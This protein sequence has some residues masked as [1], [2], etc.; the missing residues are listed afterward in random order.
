M[1]AKVLAELER[2]GLLL[3][4]DPALPSVATLVAGER[5]SGSWWG[6]P[7]G[8]RI[9]AVLSE[10]EV[11][12]D[13]VWSRLIARKVTLVHARLVPALIGVGRSRA[14]WQL[15]GLSIEAKKLLDDVDA[16]GSVRATGKPAKE[17]EL[18]LLA[19]GRTV[20]TDSGHHATELL[21]WAELSRTR[22]AL[23][24]AQGQ[25]LLERAA[26]GLGNPVPQLPWQRIRVRLR[27]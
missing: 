19:S 16:R 13:L 23:T 18:R 21:S 15:D 12:N 1:I 3:V 9:F 2:Y 6:H 14:P 17:L 10:L 27:R 7:A 26:A 5:I 11:R 24:Q 4:Q 25:E 22:R 20:H 8:K